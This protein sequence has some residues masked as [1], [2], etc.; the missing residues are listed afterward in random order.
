MSKQAFKVKP[1]PLESGRPTIFSVTQTFTPKALSTPTMNAHIAL[2]M[3]GT[4]VWIVLPTRM[5]VIFA[6]AAAKELSSGIDLAGL[7]HGSQSAHA[8]EHLAAYLPALRAREQVIEIWTVQRDGQATPMSCRLSLLKSDLNT[9][10]ILAEG[11]LSSLPQTI[12]QP[13]G[14][15]SGHGFYET[16]FHAISAP[17][18]LID[19]ANDGQIVDANLAA[20]QFYGYSREAFCRK[21]T[22]DINAAGR[23]IVP[24]MHEVAKLPGGHK[25][26]NFVHRLADGSLRD[27]QTYAGPLEL[28]GRR[29]ML[30]IIHDVTEQ[31]RL[32]SEL[33]NAASRDHLTGLWNRRHFLHLLENT[34]L[35]KR[36]NDLNYCLMLMDADYFKAIN[37][38][39][40]HDTG[41]EVL[42]LLAKT[43][44]ARVRE[45]D[46][47]CRWGGEEF[48][49][50]LPQTN[51][52]NAASLAEHLRS[53]IEK[54]RVAHL[55]PITIS[56]GVAQHQS[57]ETAE[58]LLKRA[59]A[60][61]YRA[62]NL[63]RNR[64]ALA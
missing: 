15:Q 42:T 62:K 22:W 41:D 37:D 60:A 63:G 21:Y 20:T 47:V 23:E 18:L 51:L 55:P 25:P 33:E 39:Y 52:G 44:E 6:N 30:C 46:T 48:I 27:V 9:E 35:Q 36:R 28:E 10:E 26:L 58:N 31:K 34:H 17:M 2:N 16:L 19:T 5:E 32:K 24:I 38:Q 40:G 56:I 7:R 64:V 1:Y 57:G 50:L 3:L 11:V 12:I 53:A 59:D 8:E 45:T 4:P 43:F 29:L 49:V 61:L 13:H 54:T 14:D